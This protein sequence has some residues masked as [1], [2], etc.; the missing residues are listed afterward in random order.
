MHHAPR[1]EVGIKIP[2]NSMWMEIAFPVSIT[3]YGNPLKKLD[4]RKQAAVQA[5]DA[6]GIVV[7]SKIVE[8]VIGVHLRET[9]PFCHFE[10]KFNHFRV[11]NN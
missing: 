8:L 4:P 10:W 5:N 9:C 3:I 2:R 7:L 11:K 6:N 1:M